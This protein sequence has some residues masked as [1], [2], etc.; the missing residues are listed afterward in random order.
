M[1]Y[2]LELPE[3]GQPRAWFAY[4]DEDFSRKVAAQDALQPWEIYDKLTAR[5]LLQDLGHAAI[6]APARHGHFFDDGHDQPPRINLA[7]GGAGH[8]GDRFDALARRGGSGSG[9]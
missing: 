8:R 7:H 1:I 4:D 9:G 2:V 3:Q 5:E 6:D